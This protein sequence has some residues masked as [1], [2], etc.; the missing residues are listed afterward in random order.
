MYVNL[1]YLSTGLEISWE[2]T[3]SYD[4]VQYEFLNQINIT[5]NTIY[6][7][8]YKPKSLYFSL[9]ILMLK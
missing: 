1:F 6:N 3:I 4:R 9:I 2:S 5:K 8:K 7:A